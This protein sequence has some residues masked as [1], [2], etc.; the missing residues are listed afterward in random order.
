MYVNE[1]GDSL[2]EMLLFKRIHNKYSGNM[3]IDLIYRKT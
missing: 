2:L 1:F 3:L